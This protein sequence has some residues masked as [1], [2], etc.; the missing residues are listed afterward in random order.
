M[1]FYEALASGTS[2]EELEKVFR[3]DLAAAQEKIK[4]EKEAAAAE[5]RMKEAAAKLKA[6]KAEGE[7]NKKIQEQR[8]ILTEEF[9][10]YIC[11]LFGDLFKEEDEK[12]VPDSVIEDMY[13]AIEK[14]IIEFENTM[15]PMIKL[16]SNLKEAFGFSQEEKE[17]TPDYIIQNFLNSL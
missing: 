6:N 4:K 16:A 11:L 2:A 17:E 3:K 7:K 14:K 9:T 5:A 10:T 1:D 12:D 15:L 8:D 13:D